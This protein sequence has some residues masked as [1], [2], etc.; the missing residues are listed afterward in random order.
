MSLAIISL[1]ALLIIIVISCFIPKLNPGLLSLLAALLIGTY[2]ANLSVNQIVGFFP[3]NLFILLLSMTFVFGTA[4]QNGTL[5][6]LTQRAIFLIKGQE[7]LLPLLIFI[8]AF[9]LSALGP[10]N[11]AAV[12]VLAPVAMVLAKQRQISPLVV[13]IML[14]TGANAGAFSPFSPTGIVA[15]GLIEKIHVDPQLIWVVFGASAILQSLSAI[16][17]YVI[18]LIRTQR[19][20]KTIQ[21]VKVESVKL[22]K[23]PINTQQKLTMVFIS[24]LLLGVIAFKLPLITIALITAVLMFTFNLSTEEEVIQ[25]VPWSTILMVTGIAVL[26]G[27]ME[28]TGGLDL[29]T[30]TIATV[31]SPQLINAALAFVTG[32]VSA[33]SS[34]SGVVLPAFIPLIPGLAQKMAIDNI[35]PLI[36]AVAVGS[37]MV[38]VS[39]LSTL[40]ALSIAAVDKKSTRDRMFKLLLTWGMSMS[41][42]GGAIAYIFLDVAI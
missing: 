35:I 27:L 13:A 7:L 20:S 36:I 19:R 23:T 5:E 4:V 37:H 26:I 38:D 30:T 10:G 2:G 11:I 6:Q 29:A 18:F 3:T 16:L 1:L 34:S 31:T 40:G 42:V 33:Y 22:Q 41:V 28:K 24:A 9:A 17:A 39:P 32:V 14:C 21:N 25:T 8:L 15:L 12:A